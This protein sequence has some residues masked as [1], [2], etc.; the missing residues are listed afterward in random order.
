VNKKSESTNSEYFFKIATW[1]KN[2][3]R[4]DFFV[5]P[6]CKHQKPPSTDST[7]TARA[8][9][10]GRRGF[11]NVLP[12]RGLRSQ[13]GEGEFGQQPTASAAGRERDGRDET[14]SGTQS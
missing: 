8:H 10:F 6:L 1:S 14:D 3:R 5:S 12:I 2:S 4:V 13:L 9:L 7:L 11:A